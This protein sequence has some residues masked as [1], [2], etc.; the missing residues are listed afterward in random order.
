VSRTLAELVNEAATAA[1]ERDA[2]ALRKAAEVLHGEGPGCICDDC[3]QR[4]TLRQA[5]V[6]NCS[7][8]GVTHA[9]PRCGS[10]LVRLE[11]MP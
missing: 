1:T 10:H 8:C 2:A 9:C 5:R 7:R 11:V 4:C 3:K 6:W